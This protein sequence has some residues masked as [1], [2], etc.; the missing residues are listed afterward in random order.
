MARTTLKDR[1]Q[2]RQGFLVLIE[3]VPGPGRDTRPI[4][5]FLQ[6]LA[7]PGRKEIPECFCVSA[8]TFPHNPGGVAN[9]EPLLLIT[10]I[11]D[12]GLAGDL[13]LI[14]HVT[15]KD[16]NS[17]GLRSLLSSYLDA[18]IE[19]VLLLTGDRPADGK[20]VFELD[21]LGLLDLVRLMNNQILLNTEPSRLAV[22]RRFFAGAAVSPFK[23]TEASLL[24]QYYKLEKKLACGAQYIIT[25]V[26]WDWRKSQEL[27]LYLARRNITVPVFGNVYLLTSL[28]AAPRLM[29]D[30]KLPGCFVSD[31][32]L[33]RIYSEDLDAHIERAAQQVS[34]YRSL[35]A[36][37]VDIAGVEDFEVFI[38]ILQ[39]A[40]QIGDHWTSH[41]ENLCWP[42]EDPFYLFDQAGNQQLLCEPDKTFKHRFFNASHRL[43]LDKRYRGFRAFRGLMAFFGA[44]KEDGPMYKLFNAFEQAFKYL[45]FECQHC[46]DCFLPENFGLCTMGGCEKGLDNPPCGDATVEGM[47]G[48]DPNRICI[49]ERIYLAAAAESN[50]RD[51]LLSTINRPRDPRL[52]GTSSIINYLFD[53]DHAMSRK[54]I[55]IGESIHASIPKVGQ[56]MRQLEDSGPDGYLG[57]NPALDYMKALIESQADDGADY[58]AVNVDAFGEDDVSKAVEMMRRYVRLV[59]QWG[60]GVPVCVDSGYNQVLIAGLEEWYKTDRPVKPPLVNS[61]KTYTVDQILPLR[62][63]FDFAVVGLL[64]GEGSKEGQR[65]YCSI[66]QV[67]RLAEEIFD[68]AVGRYGFRPDQ[69]FFDSTVFPLAIDMPMEPGVPGYTYRTFETIKQIRSLPKFKGVHCSLGI[70]NCVRDLPGRKVGVCRAYL[71]KAMEYGLDA[72][73]VNVSH[74]YGSVEPASDLLELVDA[75]AK[76]DGSPERTQRAMELMA[77]FCQQARKPS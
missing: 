3:L 53:R 65:G 14:A 49:G 57:P 33:E 41:K 51:R 66:D 16:H 67:V 28:N 76:M 77:R 11:Q 39:R 73:I 18:G 70:S 56:V 61:V 44:D 69:L 30:G 43:L 74:K 68:A 22:A 5:R 63:R 47:C 12:E 34:M 15:C 19:T 62:S 1:L 4:R 29:H 60:K 35:G 54:L 42:P 26:G 71:A 27:F 6:A 21:S 20:G 64:V 25:Q 31:Q 17:A 38:R 59:R 8:L 52:F 10:Q 23:Y 24:Q 46:G 75:Y 45:V 50:G 40:A 58:I 48:N 37:G 72:A 2:A 36:A 55:L 13:D 7:G 32:L 9:L